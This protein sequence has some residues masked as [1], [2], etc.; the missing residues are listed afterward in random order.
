MHGRK[1]FE[2]RKIYRGRSP[3][4]LGSVGENSGWEVRG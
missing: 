2:G 3:R 4:V 1:L